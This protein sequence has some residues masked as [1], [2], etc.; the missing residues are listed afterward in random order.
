VR[1]C[2]ELREHAERTVVASCLL[3]AIPEFRQLTDGPHNVNVT[4]GESAVVNCSAY[5]EPRANVEWFENGDR[6]DRKSPH[7]NTKVRF[8]TANLSPINLIRH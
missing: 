2:R 6:L 4:E 1:D 5:A 8:S 7:L 3:T